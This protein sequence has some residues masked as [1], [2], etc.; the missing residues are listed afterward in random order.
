MPSTVTGKITVDGVELDR[1][2]GEV[3]FH[4]MAGGAMVMSSLKADGSYTLST[5]GTSGLEPGEYQV[6][7]RVVQSTPDPS[8]NNAPSQQPL[9]HAKYGDKTK[10]GLTA[11]V[12]PGKNEFDFDVTSR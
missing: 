6:T 5:G 4:P 8:G 9:C 11:T 1:A 7:V 10:S 12:V 3:M 2:Q